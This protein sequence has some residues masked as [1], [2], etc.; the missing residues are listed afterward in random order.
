MTTTTATTATDR[1]Y[2]ISTPTPWAVT[3]LE[4]HSPTCSDIAHCPGTKTWD[5]DAPTPLL[6]LHY[7]TK[8]QSF[9]LLT[10][11]DVIEC[12]CC[13]TAPAIIHVAG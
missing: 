4:V 11:N 13:S 1:Q 2:V 8:I 12:E 7:L 3:L 9:P 10:L 5:V 6:A